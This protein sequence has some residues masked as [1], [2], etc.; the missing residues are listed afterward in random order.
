MTVVSAYQ[1]YVKSS[2]RVETTGLFHEDNVTTDCARMT[3]NLTPEH[4]TDFQ[5]THWLQCS[6]D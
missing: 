6:T 1:E 5:E 4:M 3:P 2:Q